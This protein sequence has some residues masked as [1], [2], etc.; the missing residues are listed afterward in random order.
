MSSNLNPTLADLT[1]RMTQD[2]KIDPY[3]VEMLNE[4]NE[5]L[6]DATWQ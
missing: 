1:S 6:E 2:G 4:T 5:M 3:I